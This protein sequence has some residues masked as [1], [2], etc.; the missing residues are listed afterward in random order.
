MTS[1]SVVL[2]V[3]WLAILSLILLWTT[4]RVLRSDH[5]PSGVDPILGMPDRVAVYRPSSPLIQPH[6]N[7]L[8]PMPDHL[9]TQEEMVAWMTKEMPRVVGR[10]A[11]R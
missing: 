3:C 11:G 5:E 8:V 9:T 10:A 2:V 6:P 1:V 4:S 7:V